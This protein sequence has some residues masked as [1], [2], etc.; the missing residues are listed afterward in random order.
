MSHIPEWVSTARDIATQCRLGM[1]LEAGVAMADFLPSMANDVSSQIDNDFL[2]LINDLNKCHKNTD[3]LG[4]ADCLEFELV[5][6]LERL[7]SALK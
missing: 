3:W 6:W 2:V 1:T 5:P 4:V 7:N